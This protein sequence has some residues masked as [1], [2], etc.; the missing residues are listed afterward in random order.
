MRKDM[1]SKM[2]MKIF[3]KVISVDM[4]NE[5]IKTNKEDFLWKTSRI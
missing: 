5:R 1:D 4:H 3:A 2:V